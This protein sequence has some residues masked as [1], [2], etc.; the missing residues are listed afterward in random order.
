MAVK[1]V[2]GQGVGFTRY[3]WIDQD[4]KKAMGY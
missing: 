3:F 1:G 2:Y 4:L